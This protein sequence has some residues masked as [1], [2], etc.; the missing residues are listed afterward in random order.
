MNGGELSCSPNDPL[1][2]VA[3]D[4]HDKSREIDKDNLKVS[5]YN[6]EYLFMKHNNY[7]T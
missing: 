6:I 1:S 3:I 7:Y 4:C 5:N 2:A